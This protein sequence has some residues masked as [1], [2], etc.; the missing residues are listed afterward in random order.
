MVLDLQQS[1][2]QA[3]FRRLV[4]TA[5]VVLESFPVGT[6]KALGLD[7][8]A[9]RELNPRLIMASITPFGQTG[10]YKRHYR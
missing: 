5:D 3:L 2:G 8:H 9:L 6:L 7:Y 10:P 4:Q 1:D